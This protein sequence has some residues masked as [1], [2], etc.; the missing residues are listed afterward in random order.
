M[1]KYIRPK[2]VGD[3]GPPPSSRLGV[4]QG[5][6][7]KGTMAHKLEFWKEGHARRKLGDS[8]QRAARL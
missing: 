4:S 2:R 7:F 8:S 5:S 1:N 6:P 3:G